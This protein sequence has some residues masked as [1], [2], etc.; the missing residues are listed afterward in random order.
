MDRHSRNY[1]SLVGEY[2]CSHL[3]RRKI[4]RCKPIPTIERK[5]LAVLLAISPAGSAPA[6]EFAVKAGQLID[7][8]GPADLHREFSVRVRELSKASMFVLKRKRNKGE[9]GRIDW[10]S[11]DTGRVAMDA[12]EVGAVTGNAPWTSQ[13]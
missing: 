8:I 9:E 11:R 3:V 5:L 1:F 10:G 2:H 6:F 13:R 12:P 7:G 4:S